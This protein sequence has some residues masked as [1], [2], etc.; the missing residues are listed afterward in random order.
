MVFSGGFF[1]GL[2]LPFFFHYLYEEKERRVW[3][4]DL[5]P[6]DLRGIFLRKD[7]FLRSQR[8]D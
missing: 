3:E 7:L 5:S 4:E 8:G 2:R 1:S 6:R